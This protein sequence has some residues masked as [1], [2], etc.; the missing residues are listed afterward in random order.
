[1]LNPDLTVL[2]WFGVILALV[3]GLLVWSL[4]AVWR[5]QRKAERAGYRGI[6]E[7]MRAAPRTDAEKK[8]AVNMA[9]KGVALC[10]LGIVFAPFALLGVVPLYYGGRKITLSL[11]GLD[12]PADADDVA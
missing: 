12:L 10:L 8:D 6:S 2:L 3:L 11:L 5:T 4:L 9:M 1:M 7:Y